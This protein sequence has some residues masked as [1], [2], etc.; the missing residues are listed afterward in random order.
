MAKAAV[1]AVLGD[2]AR[3]VISAAAH[4]AQHQAQALFQGLADRA[5]ILMT[6]G[7]PLAS[8]GEQ[9][10]AELGAAGSPFAPALRALDT[11]YR[12][13]LGQGG[14][15]GTRDAYTAEADPGDPFGWVAVGD[16]STCDPC[17]DRDGQVES[18]AGW[19]ER[20][21]PRTLWPPDYSEPPC[22]LRDK[23]CRCILEPRPAGSRGTGRVL[24]RT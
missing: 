3:I 9:L 23:R 22:C 12:E 15:A 21:P 20:G 19:D 5:A 11:T 24:L 14:F 6:Q 16:D 1:R 18:L 8:V 7:Q 4:Q 17:A 13:V 10:A 2:K